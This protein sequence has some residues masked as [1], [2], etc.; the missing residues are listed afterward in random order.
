MENKIHNNKQKDAMINKRYN[1]KQKDMTNNRHNDELKSVIFLYND[2]GTN[3][4]DI[5]TFVFMMYV[6]KKIMSYIK[7]MKFKKM[8]ELTCTLYVKRDS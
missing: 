4:K 3:F 7:V 2:N 1:N 6:C 5:E 8:R